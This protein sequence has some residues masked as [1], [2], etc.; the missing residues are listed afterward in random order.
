[1]AHR[2]QFMPWP[3]PLPPLAAQLF[4]SSLLLLPRCVFSHYFMQSSQETKKIPSISSHSRLFTALQQSLTCLLS[5]VT[6]QTSHIQ[7]QRY[8]LTVSPFLCYHESTLSF[9]LLLCLEAAK[10][11]KQEVGI[12]KSALNAKYLL[13]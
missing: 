6:M 12:C 4:Q 5:L 13:N 7:K 3:I 10:N 2:A 8:K 11:R 1:M 9:F